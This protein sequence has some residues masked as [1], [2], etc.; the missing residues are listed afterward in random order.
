[1][2]Y[3]CEACNYS[4]DKCS[5]Y[6]DH[7]K[8]KKHEKNFE[9]RAE[10]SSS[11]KDEDSSQKDESS[12]QKDEKIFI[13]KNQ[14][15]CPNCNKYISKSN[16]SRHLK[17]CF[18]KKTEEE[19]EKVVT[20]K[21]QEI[22]LELDTKLEQEKIQLENKLKEKEIIEKQLAR[23]KQF[24]EQQLRRECNEVHEMYKEQIKNLMETINKKAYINYNKLNSSFVINNFTEAY[25][26]EE[27][28]APDLTPEEIK[29]YP[30]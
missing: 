27:L 4:T 24:I 30:F 25:N 1:M 26:Y 13:S 23:E 19:A 2:K 5:S 15:T 11:Q 6:K 20:K 16:I 14:V 22:K 10:F 21:I 7:I 9:I 17:V 3:H 18:V 29:L 12:S 28:M 8:S